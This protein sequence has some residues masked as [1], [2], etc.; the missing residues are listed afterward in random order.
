VRTHR[1]IVLP[2]LL[3]SQPVARLAAWLQVILRRIAS[4]SGLFMAVWAGVTLTIGIV[5]AIPIYAETTGYRILLGAL[6]QENAGDTL[7]PFAMVYKYGGARDP[8]ITWQQY[9]RVDQLASDI[10]RAGVGLP[11]PPAVRYAATEKLRVRFPDGQGKEILFARLGFQSGFESQIRYTQGAAAQPYAGVGPLDVVIS[12]TT[13]SKHTLLVDDVYALQ[14]TSARVPINLTVR[15]AGIWRPLNPADPYWFNPPSTLSDVLLA[16]EP[17]V[18]QVLN[19]ADV[20]LVSFASWYSAIDGAAVRSGDVAPLTAQIESVTADVAQLLPNVRLD[21]SPLEALARHREQVRVLTV[22]LALSS[23]PLLALIGY[24][25]VQISGMLVAR[26]QSEVAV[27]RSRGSSRGQVLRLAIGEALVVGGAA[28]VVGVPLG[29]AIAVAMTWTQSFLSFAVLPGP[30]PTLLPQSWLH[31]AATALMVIPAMLAP[32]SAAARRTILAFRQERGRAGT[33]AWWQRAWLDV[34]LVIPAAYGYLQLRQHG[35]IGIPG[36]AASTDDPFRNPLLLL[37]P[38][39]AACALALLAVRALPRLLVLG[40]W[41][42]ERLPGVALVTAL[43]ALARAPAAYRDPVLLIGL[44]LSLAIFTAAMAR[45]LDTH[46]ADRARYRAGA[47][48]RLAPVDAGA[49][50]ASIAGDTEPELIRLAASEDGGTSFDSSG[51]VVS[52]ASSAYMFI[53]MEVFGATPGV[54]AATRVAASRAPFTGAAGSRDEVIVY[55]VDRITLPG[56]ITPMWRADYAAES[57]GALMNRLGE[58]QEAALVSAAFAEAQGL[59]LGDRFTLELSDVGARQPVSFIVVGTLQFFPTLYDE[60]DPFVIINLQYSFDQQGAQYPYEVWLDLAPDAPAN[61]GDV[62]ALTYGLRRLNATADALLRLDVLRPER[63]GLFGLLSVGFLATSVVSTIGFL[64]AM[65]LAFQRRMVELGVLRA[66]GLSQR[67]LIGLLAIEQA[68]VIGAGA[69]IGSLI[70]TLISELFIPFLQVRLGA[71]PLTP[72][73]RVIIP[74]EQVALVYA[75][76]GGLLVGTVLVI[77]VLLRRMRIFE[78]VKLG[79]AV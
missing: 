68:L 62:L 10:Q 56:V 15:I 16:P 39:L 25:T 46:S 29:L 19:I 57:L 24:F 79:E 26:Q 2:R 75:V 73:F 61:A 71:F 74:W 40:A 72:P 70:G 32:A 58:Y 42:A 63:Q 1:R 4:R 69:L 51:E 34:W 67:Q 8:A 43:R 55:G 33:A 14:A 65:V 30:M 7:P 64:A 9:Q 76:A 53:P 11:S 3:P 38:A 22:T 17:S 54:A 66:V 31:G 21:R 50:T 6:A 5:V 12:E 47:D 13:A 28:W 77:F 60:G 52:Q 35:T 49:T 37:A 44:T 23:V 41:I 27:L 48:V 59:R 45:T 18:A 20:P 36:V 78:A